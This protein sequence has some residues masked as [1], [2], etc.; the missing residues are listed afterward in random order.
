VKVYC[1]GLH[2]LALCEGGLRPALAGAVGT[3]VAAAR[4]AATGIYAE[5]RDPISAEMR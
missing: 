4:M 5:E 2:G 3:L 1:D